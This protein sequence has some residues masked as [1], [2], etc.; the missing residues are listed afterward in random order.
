MAD[1]F[2]LLLILSQPLVYHPTIYFS[3]QKACSCCQEDVRFSC[4]CQSQ[5]NLLPCVDLWGKSSFPGCRRVSL[6]GRI[7]GG[8]GRLWTIILSWRIKVVR[9]CLLTGS[10]RGQKAVTNQWGFIFYSQLWGWPGSFMEVVDVLCMALKTKGHKAA[11]S[12]VHFS[13]L[14]LFPR[15]Y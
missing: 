5:Y 15:Y 11:F 4:R 3:H 10:K 8:D 7:S 1:P 2:E 9:V 6:D 12:V 13:S 14:Y